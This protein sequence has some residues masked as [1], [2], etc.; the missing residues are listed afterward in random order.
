MRNCSRIVSIAGAIGMALIAVAGQA[1]NQED[2]VSIQEVAKV[3]QPPVRY[4]VSRSVGPG[5]IVKHHAGAPGRVVRTYEIH[6]ANGKVVRQVLLK[7]VRTEPKPVIMRIGKQGYNA[8]RSG[9]VRGRVLTMTATAYLP[10]PKEMGKRATGRTANGM[11][12]RY[13]L[14]A[15]DPRV[16]PLGTMLFVEGYGLALAADTGGAIKGNKIDLCMHDERAIRQF[17]RRKVVVHILRS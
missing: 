10:R 7:E 5:R 2:R 4:E 17:G 16:I 1:Q 12:A 8:S 3:I 6:R 9:F 14:V 11:K 15:V 13:G